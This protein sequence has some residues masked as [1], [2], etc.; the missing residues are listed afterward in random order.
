MSLPG[1]ACRIVGP[2]TGLAT[3]FGSAFVGRA[4]DCGRTSVDPEG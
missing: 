4:Y 1:I 2:R 3:A